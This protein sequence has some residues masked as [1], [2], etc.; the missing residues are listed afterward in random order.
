MPRH[1]VEERSAGL[2]RA[3]S[4]H[5][6][7][8]AYLSKDAKKLWKEIVGARPADYFQPGSLQLLEQ[9]CETMISQRVTLGEMAQAVG[10]PERL[11]LAVR[12]M[13]DLAAVVNATA[14]KLRISV[15][16][17]VDRKSGKL[18]E[19]TPDSAKSSLLGGRKLKVVA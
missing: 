15:Q 3:G 12:T 8:P 2:W 13:K 10:D 17:E 19:K 18:D 6:M 1:S 7:P 14:V 9:F 5:P 16:T 11:A 4:E